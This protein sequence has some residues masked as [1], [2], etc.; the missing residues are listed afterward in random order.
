M[1][2]SKNRMFRTPGGKI[3]T[4]KDAVKAGLISENQIPKA[5]QEA[6]N[7]ANRLDVRDRERL[8]EAASERLGY[9]VNDDTLKAEVPA[10]S[11][12]NLRVLGDKNKND[13]FDAKLR[14]GD[15]TGAIDQ[16]IMEADKASKM[17]KEA[18]KNIEARRKEVS[19]L[20]QKALKKYPLL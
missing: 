14:R 9:K 7:L 8:L 19:E 11:K 12:P 2:A 5:K 1:V 6:F 13:F 18:I 15:I 4:T 3:V 20:T 16:S 10:P 17:A